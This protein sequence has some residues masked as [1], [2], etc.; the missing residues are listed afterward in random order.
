MTPFDLSGQ[1]ILITGGYG[2]LGS[3]V[4][5]G[6][7][8]LGAT[9]FVLARSRA[10]FDQQFAGDD[11]VAPGS[12]HFA[13]CDIADSASIGRAFAEANGATGRIDVLINNANYFRGAPPMAISD[14]D[15]E[16]SMDGGINS[17]YRCIREVGPYFEKQGQGNIINI[18]SM[19]G[20]VSP[21]FSVYQQAPKSLNP[22]HYGAAKAAIIQLT[23]YFAHYLG[24]G[25]VRVNAISPGPFPNTEVQQNRHF[26]QE[27][28]RR[29]ALGRIGDPQDLIGPT[30]FLC[31]PASAYVTG[32]NL[33][34]DGGWTAS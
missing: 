31:S 2:Y 18:A 34:V 24:A 20:M 22:P 12:V 11:P 15:W 32:H 7:A 10:K 9:V 14:Q 27:L 21:D 4:S 33:V 28:E 5:R 23:K 30:A 19:Y 13:E 25:G 17:V 1:T 3:T 6:L 16:Y 29:T 26:M 8:Q